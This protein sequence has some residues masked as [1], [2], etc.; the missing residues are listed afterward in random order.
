M[1]SVTEK[2]PTAAP[3][4]WLMEISDL[5]L[6]YEHERR[7][8][9]VMQGL[10][11]G[12]N[13]GEFVSIL[14]PSGC[15]KS[16]LLH[17]IAGLPPSFPPRAGRILLDAREVQRPGR[18]RVMV[19]QEY[20][21]YPWLS[22]KGNIEFPLNV[23]G[24]PKQEISDR[25]QKYM[26]LVSLADFA[27]AYPHQLSGGMKQRVAIAR[28]LAMRPRVLLM[29]EPFAAVDALTRLELQREV[30]KIWELE[31]CTILFVTHNIDE[32]LFLGTRVIVL[33]NRP[34]KVLLDQAIP[35]DIN[36]RVNGQISKTAG[37]DAL[38]GRISALL[39]VT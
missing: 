39:G 38:R 23:A 15:G 36:Q 4:K 8:V 26:A 32:A 30:L 25:S 21:I 33:S 12:V 17:A 14:G 10:S 19:F 24:L 29:D 31:H 28:S 5:T 34:A 6:S 20:A 18:D 35:V 2:E 3:S 11:F 27:D 13:S 22:V 7:T 37:M 1:K 9:E 16:S